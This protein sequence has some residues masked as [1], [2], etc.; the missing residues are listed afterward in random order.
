[1]YQFFFY[2]ITRFRR[3]L[4]FLIVICSTMCDRSKFRSR[5]LSLL[6]DS[7]VIDYQLKTTSSEG[8]SSNMTTLLALVGAVPVRLRII[9]SFVVITLAGCGTAFISGLTSLLR[10]QRPLQPIFISLVIYRG[11]RDQHILFR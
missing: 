7:P 10:F 1:M 2:Y 4:H 6:G 5:C 9:F 8:E 3:Q 11:Y